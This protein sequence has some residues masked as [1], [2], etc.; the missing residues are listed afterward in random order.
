[1]KSGK[2]EERQSYLFYSMIQMKVLEKTEKKIEV[3]ETKYYLE[4]PE[5]SV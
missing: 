1:M 3:R 4:I 2:R 5:V